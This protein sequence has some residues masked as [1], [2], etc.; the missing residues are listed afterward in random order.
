MIIYGCLYTSLQPW[1]VFLISTTPDF[2]MKQFHLIPAQMENVLST[3]NEIFCQ[4][5]LLRNHGSLVILINVVWYFKYE[6]LSYHCRR[7]TYR[8]AEIK[9]N[10]SLWNS[11]LYK[12]TSWIFALRFWN[13]VISCQK[14]TKQ[15][16]V[17]R[18]K[19]ILYP[20]IINEGVF[21][22]S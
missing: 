9:L 6:I 8:C 3:K 19:I 15:A 20:I 1:N 10:R 16:S 21:L 14:W 4:D 12:R 17:L 7:V 13:L 22:F 2:E 5:V 11:T 18:K